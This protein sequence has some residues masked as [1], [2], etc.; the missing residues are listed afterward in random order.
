M[1]KKFNKLSQSF[2]LINVRRKYGMFNYVLYLYLNGNIIKVINLL[3][4]KYNTY[5]IYVK[6]TSTSKR[7]YFTEFILLLL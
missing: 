3:E 2:V 5:T 7:N 4:N 1:T 6:I